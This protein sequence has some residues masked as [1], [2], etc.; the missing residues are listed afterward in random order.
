MAMKRFHVIAAAV[1][2][3]FVLVQTAVAEENILDQDLDIK[4]IKKMAE[5][6]QLINLIYNDQ[7]E[8]THRMHAVVINA[9]LDTVWGVITDYK[10]YD[11]F[12]PEMIPP[13][14]RESE[15]DRTIVD[16]TLKIRII[17][18]V[19]STQEYSTMYVEEKPVLHML[20][21]D[22]PDEEGGFWK[23]VPVENGE[24]TLAFYYDP[25]PDLS[26]M[27]RLVAGV[28]KSK[29]EFAIAL[30]V[31]PVTILMNETKAYIEKIA[32]GNSME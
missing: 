23:L 15:D 10:N 22:K 27:G 9:D 17:M 26:E 29:P 1:L 2:C 25:V 24:K 3:L 32:R 13:K 4:T 11:K 28:A 31:S 12:V 30:Q 14:I 8:L 6:G 20:N 7:G 16:F 21:P 19:S 18:G 5:H